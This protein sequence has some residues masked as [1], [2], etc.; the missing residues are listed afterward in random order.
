M[1][2]LTDIFHSVRLDS[3]IFCRADLDHPWSLYSQPLPVG[4]FHAV[5]EGRC[6]LTL[7]T[8]GT[9]F[10]LERGDIVLMPH[11]H[12][13]VMSSSDTSVAIPITSLATRGDSAVDYL[14]LPG[15]G[16]RTRIVCG[17]VHFE[18]GTVHP[19]FKILPDALHMPSP[20]AD[21]GWRLSTLA[22]IQHEVE[23]NQ[24]GAG[25]LL[26]RLAEAL[27]IDGLRHFVAALE[28]GDGEWLGGLNDP[29]VARAMTLIHR[30]PEHPWT[31][32]ALAE[33]V[34]MSRSGLY[35]RFT[36][37]VG[38][39]PH[40]YLTRWRLQLASKLLIGKGLSVAK[41]AERVGYASE[42]AFSRTFKRYVGHS[43]G[44]H[45]GKRGD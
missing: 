36:A 14:T 15:P 30:Q 12:A 23:Q 5:I 16:E 2:L 8:S 4:I 1:D 21:S 42:A 37:L 31:A 17:R 28:P 13:H 6:L 40:R 24:P 34:G 35:N 29:R 9:T 11:G 19:L 7:E 3:T 44:K 20:A 26:T 33:E 45:K 38:L 39:P 22:R 32:A 41:V 27:L 10:E 25:A 18:H 43:P